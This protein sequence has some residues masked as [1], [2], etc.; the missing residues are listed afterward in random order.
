MALTKQA[1]VLSKRQID[2]TLGYLESTRHPI[3]NRLI[4]LLSIQAG[5][6]A[7]E[8]SKLDWSMVTD[9]DGSI[10]TEITLYNK[11]SKGK[12]G[13]RRIPMAKQIRETLIEHLRVTGKVQT[14]KAVI[15]SER[16]N[17]MSPRTVVCFF[18]RLYRS[19]GFKGASSH[20]GRR[21]FITNAARQIV[22]AGGSLREVQELAG[23]SNLQVT[24]RYIDV[25]EDAK[26][27]VIDM[28]Y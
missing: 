23:H 1:K 14:D 3:R 16:G 8:I 7:I 12:S 10:S 9:V 24:S 28:L 13:G 26:R 19:L 15:L 4:F 25:N 21:S 17:R 22:K 6:R 2:Q 11:A 18:Q 5:L 27:K 20:S